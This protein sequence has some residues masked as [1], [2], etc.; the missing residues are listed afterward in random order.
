MINVFEE[1]DRYVGILG[2][3]DPAVRKGLLRVSANPKE[4]SSFRDQLVLMLK[5]KGYDP[6]DLPLF[7]IET[8]PIGADG[9]TLGH[10]L[11]GNRI[12]GQLAISIPSF[13]GHVLVAGITRAGKTTL[14]MQLIEQIQRIGVI[15]VVFDDQ[16]EYKKLVKACPEGSLVVL[17][18][19]QDKDSLLEPPSGV[20]VDEWIGK[21]INLLRECWYLR[22][23][24]CNLLRDVLTNACKSKSQ[25]GGR[26]PTVKDVIT[27]L[28]AME[29]KPG[30][31]HAGYLETLLNRFN[32]LGSL[33]KTFDCE[34]GYPIEKLFGRS[35]V[36]RLAGLSDDLRLLYTNLK[37]ARFCSYREKLG[38]FDQLQFL[39]VIEEAHKFTSPKLEMRADLV[40]PSIFNLI[41]T[42]GKRG[43][44]IVLIE[45]VP[46]SLPYQLLGN[47]NT[48]IVLRLGDSRSI[49]RLAELILLNDKQ[50]GQ[51]PV[52]PFRQGIYQS[53]EYPNAVL[54]QI[55]ERVYE[56]VTEEEVRVSSEAI[57]ATMEYTPSSQDDTTIRVQIPDNNAKE[58]RGWVNVKD[59]HK[60]LLEDIR[61][62]PFDGINER[63]E[64]MDNWSPWFAQKVITELEQVGFIKTP[65]LV[66]LGGRG[67]PKKMLQLSEK[68]A[69]FIGVDYE[70]LQLKGKGSD[71][72]KFL[73]NMIAEKFK[74]EGKIAFVEYTL[75]GK[76]AD[77]VVLVDDLTYH[78]FELELDPTNPHVLE[79]VKRDLESFATCTIISRNRQAENQIK[80][81]IYKTIS[82]EH[83]HRVKFEL[84]KNMLS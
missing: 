2:K 53:P 40:E 8:S 78:G 34:K 54:F 76:S 65:V 36:F 67:N 51:I 55:S 12:L 61:S 24:C 74:G 1:I 80:Q 29:F 15:V 9:V 41:R 37:L 25:E 77:V 13:T 38:E 3:D 39:I 28:Q 58:K 23:G 32:G 68:G 56:P 31:R 6:T 27:A 7:C 43:A 47:I 73:Q 17:T 52:L 35:V 69:K 50:A 19:E 22:D 57:L 5:K 63:R 62:H 60:N 72:H 71:E 79:N 45:Q 11:C 59:P 4:A 14:V 49:Y 75:N 33:S 42:I 64:R 83:L 48:K 82:F 10:V 66:S 46:A 26:F 30:T 44:S 21:L 84:L 16:D 81:M 20:T 18:P 70:S